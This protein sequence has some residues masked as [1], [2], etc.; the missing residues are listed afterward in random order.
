MTF[1]FEIVETAAATASIKENAFVKM[2]DG[3]ES[4]F[5]ELEMGKS[6][7]FAVPASNPDEI[8]AAEKLKK[9][10]GEHIRI[11]RPE[12]SPL[13]KSRDENGKR[14]FVATIQKQIKRERTNDAKGGSAAKPAAAKAGK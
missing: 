13:V 12:Y 1:Q 14:T 4:P 10:L 11:V 2:L 6:I 3:A 7:T 5:K 9:D 8:K